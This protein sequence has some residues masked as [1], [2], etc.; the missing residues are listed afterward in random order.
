M[1]SVCSRVTSRPSL[2]VA[3][4]VQPGHVR[5]GT[6]IVSS[7]KLVHRECSDLFFLLCALKDLALH[8]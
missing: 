1:G 8:L 5:P 2:V 6:G 3:A 7:D 4:T